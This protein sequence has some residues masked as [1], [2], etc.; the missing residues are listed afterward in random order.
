ME[1]VRTRYVS[2]QY[3]GIGGALARLG[4]VGFLAGGLPACSGAPKAGKGG[5]PAAAESPAGAAARAGLRAINVRTAPVRT[6]DVTYAIEAVGSLETETQTQVVA[7]VEGV[8]S[9]VR[10]HEGDA[11]TPD[12]ILATID[13]D[14][15]RVQADRARANREKIEAEYNRAVSDQERRERLAGETPSLVSEEEVEG[16]RQETMRL[17]AS[18]DEA[19]ALYELARLDQERSIVRPLV[20]GVINSKTVMVGQ[21]VEAKDVLAV[22]IDAL[23]LNL[24]FKVSEQESTRIRTGQEI[25]F[26]TE[27]R[28]GKEFVA[29]VFHVSSVA[30]PSTRMVDVLARVERDVGLL[31][32]G[33][34]A[35]VRAEV[36][37]HRGAIV[38]P[39]R[40]LLP[41]ER[42]FVTY[43]VKE[44]RAHL[45]PVELGLR[46]RDGGVEILSGLTPEAVV[47]T[48]GGDILQD[49]A[50]VQVVGE[51]GGPDADG[52]R[53]AAGDSPPTAD[54]SR[55]APIR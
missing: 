33:F 55:A 43:E 26:T 44:G 46:T 45:R 47:V 54:D 35:E 53:G 20:P 11:V 38:I 8:V 19:R 6:L 4:L 22:L 39:E 37:S 48:D 31:R 24:R 32:P 9:S 5:E 2:R 28:P 40:S 30:D 34:F 29:T 50:P 18:L 25:R 52:P 21:H 17:R 42:G 49:G 23:R 51:P 1:T 12:T 36:A 7:G 27:P 14:R 3:S 41:T 15:F 13:P 16:A 10:F